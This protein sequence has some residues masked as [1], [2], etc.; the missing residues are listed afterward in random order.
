MTQKNKD[1]S[2]D[3]LQL[4]WPTQEEAEAFR[5]AVMKGHESRVTEITPA[6]VVELINILARQ[7]NV[8]VY[9]YE[10]RGN[11]WN[12]R[13]T[14]QKLWRGEKISHDV[15]GF[16]ELLLKGRQAERMNK[17]LQDFVNVGVLE[18]NLTVIL[19]KKA[20]FYEIYSL[21]KKDKKT[22]RE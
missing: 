16:K 22:N 4:L 18:Q 17:I 6:S 3:L 2:E 8:I 14:N 12:E 20:G 11:W 9:S 10:L 5:E 19:P 13:K 7:T 15:I 21:K 1:S